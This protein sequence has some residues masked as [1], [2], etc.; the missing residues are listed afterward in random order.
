M[1]TATLKEEFHKLIESYEDENR[2]FQYFH[3][4]KDEKELEVDITDDLTPKQE[5]R[6]IESIE[7]ADRNEGVPHE[8]AML[9]MKQWIENL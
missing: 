3:L 7:I 6:L 8:I 9:K 2:L 5:Q 1:E 4:M